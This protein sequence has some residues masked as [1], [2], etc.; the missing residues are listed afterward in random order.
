MKR[1]K[2]AR[3]LLYWEIY[4]SKLLLDTKDRLHFM[5]L[6]K[7][8]KIKKKKIPSE[9]LWWIF[10]ETQID[11][12]WAERRKEHN[13]SQTS[14]RQQQNWREAKKTK[15]KKKTSVF[16]FL[17][18]FYSFLCYFAYQCMQSIVDVLISL[19]LFFVDPHNT[20]VTLHRI[21]TH[22]ECIR[23]YFFFIN[24]MENMAFHSDRICNLF[25]S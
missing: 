15:K 22:N 19:L 18:C 4:S 25:Y 5:L 9:H 17:L 2:N 6:S 8:K 12:E 1:K 7:I 14:I 13:N 24:A 16:T 11:E 21:P 20:C 23:I 10:F 3:I